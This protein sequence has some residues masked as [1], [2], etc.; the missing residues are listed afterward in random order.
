MSESTTCRRMIDVNVLI[1]KKT[2]TV[3]APSRKG[4][5]L[6]AMTIYLQR[7]IEIHHGHDEIGHDVI[8]VFREHCQLGD[9]LREP[10]VRRGHV[11]PVFDVQKVLCDRQ[12]RKLVGK[13]ENRCQVIIFFFRYTHAMY[14]CIRKKQL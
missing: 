9:H 5:L 3:R 12:T 13:T 1:K 4:R 14:G 8:F 2:V 7:L 6:G 10:V 11:Q